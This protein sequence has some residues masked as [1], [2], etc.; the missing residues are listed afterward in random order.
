MFHDNIIIRFDEDFYIA[1]LAI[2][3]NIS[4]QHGITNILGSLHFNY[5]VTYIVVTA[6]SLRVARSCITL[7]IELLRSFHCDVIFNDN[8]VLAWFRELICSVLAWFRE[9]I[10]DLILDEN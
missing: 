2:L 8:S 5:L 3:I 1:V 6:V 4:T 10:R 7:L 9:F